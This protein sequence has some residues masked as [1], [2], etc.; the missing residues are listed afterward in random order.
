MWGSLLYYLEVK[1]H[2]YYYLSFGGCTCFISRG[3]SESPT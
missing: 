3:T 2:V 1:Y